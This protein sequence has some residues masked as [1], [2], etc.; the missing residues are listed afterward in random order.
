MSKSNIS[1][2]GSLNCADGSINLTVC[3]K[4][5]NFPMLVNVS[6]AEFNETQGD[7]TLMKSLALKKRV[8]DNGIH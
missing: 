3:L 6:I 1:S 5:D 7:Q 4:G 8:S 2:I